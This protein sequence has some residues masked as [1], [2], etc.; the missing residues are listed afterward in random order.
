MCAPFLHRASR[1]SRNAFFS[2][3]PRKSRTD[4]VFPSG[5][6]TSDRRLLPFAF[7]R[8]RATHCVETTPRLKYARTQA[9]SGEPSVTFSLQSLARSFLG[10]MSAKD[11]PHIG[12]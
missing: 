12:T 1:R 4:V 7:T 6:F 3:P 5:G 2:S 11:D 9:P 8:A 10:F